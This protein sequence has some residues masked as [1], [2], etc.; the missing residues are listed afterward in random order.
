V[1]IIAPVHGNP[2]TD[3]ISQRVQMM[4]DVNS[5]LCMGGGEERPNTSLPA[6]GDHRKGHLKM[7]IKT[8]G[9]GVGRIGVREIVPNVYWLSHCLGND[10]PQWTEVYHMKDEAM[11]KRRIDIQFSAFSNPR[12]E[13]RPL[14]YPRPEPTTIFNGGSRLRP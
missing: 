3:R 14:G 4:K 5:S 1:G 7:K 10:A 11:R 6:D 8:F 12:Q 9:E 2:I 13:V